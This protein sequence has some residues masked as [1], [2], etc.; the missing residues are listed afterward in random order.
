MGRKVLEWRGMVR[1]WG[2]DEL[3]GGRGRWDDEEIERG[4]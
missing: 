3:I 4:M 2:V 1:C